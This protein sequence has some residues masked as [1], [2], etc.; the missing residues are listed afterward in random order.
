M[1]TDITFAELYKTM[2]VFWFGLNLVLKYYKLGT[3]IVP[4]KSKEKI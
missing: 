1:N 4:S 3:F 2:Y